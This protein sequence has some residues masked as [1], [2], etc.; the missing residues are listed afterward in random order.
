MD[1]KAQA[2]RTVKGAA[3]AIANARDKGVSESHQFNNRLLGFGVPELTIN[4]TE[5]LTVF[6]VLLAI[7]LK[8]DPHL[9]L[10]EC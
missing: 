7:M 5:Y 4:V 1:E 10:A 6:M 3:S 2:L 9:H 8:L